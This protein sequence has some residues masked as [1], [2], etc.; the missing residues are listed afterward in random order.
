MPTYK[1]YRK[2]DPTNHM[3]SYEGYMMLY[4][5]TNSMWCKVFP[6]TLDGMAQYWFKNISRGSI[7]SFRQLDTIFC[8]QYVANI[9]RERMIGEFMSID[10][11]SRESLREYISRF[12]MEASNMPKLQQEV[13]VLEMMSDL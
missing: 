13:A 5:D 1:F 11:G 3:S 9:V 2:T 4:T 7:T 10:Q 6:S 12:N 8:T